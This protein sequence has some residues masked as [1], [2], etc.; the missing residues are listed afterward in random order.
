MSL[1]FGGVLEERGGRFKCIIFSEV[2]L[3]A[4]S[5]CITRCL[6]ERPLDLYDPKVLLSRFDG[7]RLVSLRGVG[8][9]KNGCAV[10]LASPTKIRHW[11]HYEDGWKKLSP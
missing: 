8:S 7:F 10:L 11:L 4:V 2:S 9:T 1:E 5:T 6:V 3:N